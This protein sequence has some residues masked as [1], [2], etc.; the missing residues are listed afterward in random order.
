L[1]PTLSAIASSA[2]SVSS[3]AWRRLLISLTFRKLGAAGLPLQHHTIRRVTV[4]PYPTS[5]SCSS[6]S[7]SYVTADGQSVSMSWCRAHSATC[8]LSEGCCLVSDKRST[9]LHDLF[10]LPFRHMAAFIVSTT[11]H[12]VQ[13]DSHSVET[14]VRSGDVDVAQLSR[15]AVDDKPCASVAPAARSRKLAC[16]LYTTS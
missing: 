4:Y 14:R 11:A 10:I 2:I 5:S 6:Y 8:D 12:I 1:P 15:P 9:L 16:I 3:A 7:Q 13:K